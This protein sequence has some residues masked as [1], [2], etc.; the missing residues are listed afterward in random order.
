MSSTLKDSALA[1]TP[2]KNR[3]IRGVRLYEERGHEIEALGGHRYS[4]PS[5]DGSK[6]YTVTTDIAG[7]FVSCECPDAMHQPGRPCKHFYALATLKAKRRAA[8]PS[9]FVAG[10]PASDLPGFEKLAVLA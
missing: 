10:V 6:R 3:A 2:T 5:C 4:V 1:P 9:R 8:R 7:E